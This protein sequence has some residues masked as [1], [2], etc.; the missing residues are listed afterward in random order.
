MASPDPEDHRQPAHVHLDVVGGIAGDMFIAALLDA[1]P[2]LV[3]GTVSA[4]R[5]SGVPTDWI[6]TPETVGDGGLTGI[7]MNIGSADATAVGGNHYRYA[8][9]V[10]SLRHA[11]LDE[12]VRSRALA[13]LQLIADAEAQVHGVTVDEVVLHELGA[14]DS[15]ADVV[16][17]AYLIEALSPTSWSTSSL[18][19]GGGFIQ[20]DHGRLPVPAP[21]TQLL[22]QGFPFV[23]D[24]IGGER[25]T[26]TGAAILRYIEP[27]TALPKG[28]YRSAETGHGF[29]T[30]TLP[31]V[32]NM[33]RARRYILQ[34]DAE[35]DEQVAVIEYMVD[36]QTPEDLAIALDTLRE[37]PGVLEV[38]QTPAVG[39]KGRLGH[40]VQVLAAAESLERVAAACF[41]QTTT[42]GL[43]YRLEH[44][45]VLSRQEVTVSDD[46]SV[47]IAE[48]PGGST[49]KAEMDDIGRRAQNH[50]QREQLRRR[51]ES[52]APIEDDHGQ[53]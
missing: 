14:L 49:V 19:V 23:D 28:T 46:V 8:D 1:C 4:I 32:P 16:G 12:P 26:P 39:K 3:E 45:K 41:E 29:G 27:A 50:Q 35:V 9:V 44:R 52:A 51:V 7:R 6:V 53:R 24:G 18:P 22:L 11:P 13:I 20:T 25:I 30:R 37:S 42:I 5:G 48:R 21:A 34:A 38:L 15:I 2:D 31:G 36:D 17:A 47:K 43:R 10:E 40:A 33:L